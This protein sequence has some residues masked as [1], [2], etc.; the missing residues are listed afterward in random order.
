MVR[1]FSV[2]CDFGGQMNPQDVYIGRPKDH[3]QHPLKFQEKWLTEERGGTIPAEVMDAVKKLQDLAKQ[4]NVPLEDLCVYALGT[5][6]E[7]RE[8]DKKNGLDSEEIDNDM[9]DLEDEL[10]QAKDE[11]SE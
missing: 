10:M 1:K 6:E 9:S 8:M 5:E 4:N 3:K 7:K 11:S 2:N